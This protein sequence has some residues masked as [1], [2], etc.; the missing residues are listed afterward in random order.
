MSNFKKSSLQNLKNGENK[1][2]EINFEMIKKRFNAWWE[3]EIVDRTLVQVWAPQSMKKDSWEKYG[4]SYGVFS[5]YEDLKKWERNGLNKKYLKL[6]VEKR[7]NIL[8]SIYYGGDAFPSFWP[9]LGPGSLAS[10]L[11][12]GTEFKN[13]TVWFG[14]PMLEDYRN[15]ERINLDKN[16]RIWKAAKDLTK[17]ASESGKDKYFVSS[18]DL[19]M[20]LDTIASLRGYERLIFDLLENKDDVKKLISKISDIFIYCNNYFFNLVSNNQKIFLGWIP[21]Y[22]DG[23]NYPLQCDFSAVIS[24]TMFEEFVIPDLI[25]ISKSFDKTIYHLDGPDAV[26]HLDVLLDL[27]EIHAIQWIPGAGTPSAVNWLEMLKKIQKKGKALLVYAES[28]KELE[29]L[30]EELEHEGLLISIKSSSVE[31][32]DFIV[33]LVKRLTKVSKK[34]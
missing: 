8:S 23:R 33:N 18:I 7:R 9:N 31:E 19:G 13:E 12:C 25:K 21:V 5:S 27:P 14:P 11:G 30:L 2:N 16:N 1:L 3:R 15:L 24:P 6:F 4:S 17:V 32:A 28:I 10:F 20:N 26:K 34:I 29:I 22:C